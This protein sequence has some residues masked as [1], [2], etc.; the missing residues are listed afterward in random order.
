MALTTEQRKEIEERLERYEG[1]EAS[2][3]DVRTLCGTDVQAL[4][5]EIDRLN[6][7]VEEMKNDNETETDD[8]TEHGLNWLGVNEGATTRQIADSL[9]EL[10]R[11]PCVGRLSEHIEYVAR[12]V[13]R[14]AKD[15]AMDE[16]YGDDDGEPHKANGSAK[17]KTAAAR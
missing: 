9:D 12:E 1:S 14:G 5:D 3:E 13:R 6:E 2:I 16:L 7:A 15:R 8:R 4:L 11:I 17:R 10:S